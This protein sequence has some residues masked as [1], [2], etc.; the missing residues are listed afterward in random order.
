MLALIRYERFPMICY[1]CRSIGH[2][3]R[4][5]E[6]KND[7]MVNR[8]DIW[9]ISEVIQS[10]CVWETLM[11]GEEQHLQPSMEGGG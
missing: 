2:T 6:K 7:S 8:Y 5:C 3:S 10:K 1:S 9:L 11:T 4:N